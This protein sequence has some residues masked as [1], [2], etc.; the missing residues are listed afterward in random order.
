MVQKYNITTTATKNFL[1]KI[2]SKR[3]L[4]PFIEKI[5]VIVV[6]IARALHLGVRHKP[7]WAVL[8]VPLV[9]RM[10]LTKAK[11]KLFHGSYMPR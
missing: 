1:P 3:R 8:R 11:H 4:A 5:S 9:L 6:A 2:M 10:G 7:H